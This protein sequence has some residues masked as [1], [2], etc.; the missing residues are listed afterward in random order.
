MTDLEKMEI[1]CRR[2]EA[3]LGPLEFEARRALKLLVKELEKMTREA[4]MTVTNGV[5]K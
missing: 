5:R 4:T 1:A 2:A 3:D